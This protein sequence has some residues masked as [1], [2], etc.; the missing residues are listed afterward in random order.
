MTHSLH[1]IVSNE[2]LRRHEFPVCAGSVFMAHAGVTALPRCAGDAI[3]E[4]AEF[5]SGS[6][7]EMGRLW[8]I[9]SQAR[10]TA[11][12][13]I[14]GDP[15]E[16]ALLGPTSV[17]LSL[18]ANGIDWQP[19]DE[20]I[21][22]HDDYPANVYPWANC[23]RKGVVVKRLRTDVLG[24]ITREQIAPL[25]TPRTRLVALA[26]CNFLSGLRLPVDE[27]GAFLKERGILFCLDAIQTLG[28]VPTST[29][30]VDFLSADSHKW[31]L[32]PLAAGI[33][34]IRKEH[35]P[36][37]HPTLIGA[38]NV[39]SPDF[40]AQEQM[41]FEET[42]R[43]YEPGAMNLIGIA[44]MQAAMRMLLDVGIGEIYAR[45]L[46]LRGVLAAGLEAKGYG[47]L[48]GDAPAHL[49]TGILTVTHPGKDLK[50][51]GKRL[52]ENKIYI[53]PRHLRDGTPLLR[54][55]PHFYNTEAEI[56]KV[57]ALL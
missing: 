55:S 46:H 51:L 49:H 52:E 33:V 15:G 40:I 7:Q 32:G 18:V 28:A 26:S 14:H 50:A 54:F 34:W 6:N 16:I 53:S 45:L 47:I 42:A 21:C 30:H 20:I 4:M 5:G 39:H 48:A 17:G 35:F 44:G 38:W 41:A 8:Q 3:K 22:Y 37:V 9:L 12:E 56:E 13:L 19:G 36:L 1:D 31:L 11:A 23:A 24:L 25:I 29:R 57:L 27:I 2:S 10:R 43:R